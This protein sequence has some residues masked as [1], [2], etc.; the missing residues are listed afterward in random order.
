VSYHLLEI[1][2]FHLLAFCT[3]FVLTMSGDVSETLPHS[4]RT[5]GIIQHFACQVKLH[6]YALN[7]DVQ[8]TNELIG[9][10][11]SAHILTNTK[12]TTLEPNF[13]V[14]FGKPRGLSWEVNCCFLL[15]VTPKPKDKPKL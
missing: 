14:I 1:A 6:T 7:E 3:S 4:P 15:L 2:R 5:R 9:Q 12:L 13:L 11:E 8:V 10:L